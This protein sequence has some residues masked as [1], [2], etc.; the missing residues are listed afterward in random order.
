MTDD[1]LRRQVAAELSWDLQVVPRPPHGPQWMVRG[2][3]RTDPRWE[4]YLA[5]A[6]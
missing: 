4:P 6:A 3:E 5:L 1:E 2:V